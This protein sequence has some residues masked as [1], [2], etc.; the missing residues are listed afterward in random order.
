MT[1]SPF[2]ETWQTVQGD[3]V[4]PTARAEPFG[5]GSV[6]APRTN[7]QAAKC[8]AGRFQSHVHSSRVIGR[9]ALWLE[10]AVR[11]GDSPSSASPWVAVPRERQVLTDRTTLDAPP[12]RRATVARVRRS[13]KRTA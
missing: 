9:R 3:E 8:L 2:G 10:C 6:P 4:Q 1:A 7:T 5:A 13:P 11:R 12:A